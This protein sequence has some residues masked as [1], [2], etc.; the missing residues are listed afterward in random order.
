MGK[1]V[2][3]EFISLDGVSEDPGGAEG[4]AHGG[5][6]FKFPAP[7]SE[8]YKFEELQAAD[9]QLL[10]YCKGNKIV[11]AFNNAGTMRYKSLDMG[12]AGVTWVDHAATAP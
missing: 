7:D 5:W 9:V 3:T 10:V 8:A 1:L 2:V 12:A 6:S 11:F 4:Y